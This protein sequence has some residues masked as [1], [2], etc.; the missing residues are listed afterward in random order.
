MRNDDPSP[1]PPAPPGRMSSLNHVTVPQQLGSSRLQFRDRPGISSIAAHGP[2]PTAARGAAAPLPHA[3]GD[4]P[5]PRFPAVTQPSPSVSAWLRGDGLPR[6]HAQ[7]LGHPELMLQ[8][9]AELLAKAGITVSADVDFGIHNLVDLASAGQSAGDAVRS[10]G[11]QDGALAP[12][13][14]L[15]LKSCWTREVTVSNTGRQVLFPPPAECM[16]QDL[17]E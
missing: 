17:A 8:H 10:G 6:L 1:P 14:G 16:V 7:L 15:P 4:R 11:A 13:D 2:I 5:A 12:S 3:H 9:E